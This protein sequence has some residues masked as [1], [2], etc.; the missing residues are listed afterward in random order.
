MEPLATAGIDGGRPGLP[1]I[2]NG[3][4][5]RPRPLS[6]ATAPLAT[7]D[8]DSDSSVGTDSG[9]IR[10]NAT[11]AVKRNNAVVD[12]RNGARGRAPPPVPER[13]TS[14]LSSSSAWRNCE[15]LTQ[16]AQYSNLGDVRRECARL[17]LASARQDDG[18]LNGTK[19]AGA[20]AKCEETEIY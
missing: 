15:A 8:S 11:A 12:Q 7:V 6:M 18:R 19:S 13:K 5:A 14:S 3:A 2:V 17:E 4:V 20:E 10:R 16:D 9:T 1:A